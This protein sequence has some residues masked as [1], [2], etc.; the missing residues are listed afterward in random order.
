[1]ETN[2]QIK[3]E[4]VPNYG[5]I[6]WFW[7]KNIYTYSWCSCCCSS[8]GSSGC[9]TLRN[10]FENYRKII[11][12]T[13]L[14]LKNIHHMLQGEDIKLFSNPSFTLTTIDVRLSMDMIFWSLF[15][16]FV[17]F[18]DSAFTVN[19]ATLQWLQTAFHKVIAGWWT[20]MEIFSTYIGLLIYVTAEINVEY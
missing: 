15:I 16:P 19:I 17:S 2:W 1:M 7:A 8:S 18:L 20:Y 3:M 6:I 10:K 12:E 5:F 14:S 11:V 13:I 4:S 9:I